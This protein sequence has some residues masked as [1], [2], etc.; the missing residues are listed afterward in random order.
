MTTTALRNKL[1]SYLEVADTKKIKAIYTMFELEIE[2]TLSA[3]VLTND[4]MEEVERRRKD[5]LS[6]KS[7]SH[8]WE[9]VKSNFG[10]KI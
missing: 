1:Q 3:N 7:K 8:N 6:G 2:E 10:K 5:Y 4:Q 9:D